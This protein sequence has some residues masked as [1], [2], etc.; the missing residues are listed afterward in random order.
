MTGNTQSLNGRAIYELDHLTSDRQLINLASAC[1]QLQ[2]EAGAAYLRNTFK[3]WTSAEDPVS[4][5]SLRRVLA[6]ADANSSPRHRSKPNRIAFDSRTID[7]KETEYALKLSIAQLLSVL[8]VHIE[9]FFGQEQAFDIRCSGNFWYPP[10]GYV[11]WH[12]DRAMPGWRLYISHAEEANKSFF[13]YLDPDHDRVVTSADNGW[14]YR[15]FRVS[16]AKPFWHAVY[17][18]TN[19]FSLGFNIS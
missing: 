16:P 10:G 4:E 6:H 11:G 9:A 2:R 3:P 15:L 8:R 5:A 7:N 17:S 1:T 14:D 13:R 12:T 18:Q 19:R